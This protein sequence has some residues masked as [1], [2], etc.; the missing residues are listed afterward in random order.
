MG[1]NIDYKSE[2]KLSIKKSI[3]L[4]YRDLSNMIKEETD[5]KHMIQENSSLL[6]NLAKDSHKRLL[7][8]LISHVIPEIDTL[9]LD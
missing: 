2:R 5:E 3:L 8:C 7:E 9:S 4:T 1:I 6:I